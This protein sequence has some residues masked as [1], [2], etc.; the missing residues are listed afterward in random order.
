MNIT[1]THT[2]HPEVIKL[3]EAALSNTGGSIASPAKNGSKKTVAAAPVKEIAAS[4][5]T[6][7][8][9]TAS[10]TAKT[11]TITI[12]QVRAAVQQ[13]AQGGKRSQIKSLLAEF[14]VENVTGLQQDQYSAFLEKVNTL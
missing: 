11:E 1:I 3:L 5:S 12:E 4:E 14:Q 6:S 2:I 8:T 13:K 9:T 7:E 10:T